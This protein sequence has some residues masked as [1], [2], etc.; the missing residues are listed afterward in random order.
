MLESE[1]RWELRRFH[2]SDLKTGNGRRSAI[3]ER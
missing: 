3:R 1:F 2:V